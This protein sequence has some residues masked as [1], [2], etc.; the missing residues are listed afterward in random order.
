MTVRDLLTKA[1]RT[2]HV[3]GVGESMTADDATDAFDM[4]NGLIEQTNIDKL[5]GNYQTD[6]IIPL[7]GGQLSYTIGPSSA[8]PN[9]IATRP[10]EILSGFSRRGNIDL[11]IF[12]GTKL[13]YNKIPQ[14]NVGISG[15]EMLA[16]YEAAYPVA[17]LYLYP[18]PLDTLTSVYL[19][20]MNALA[21]FST[22]D[23]VVS[24]PPGYRMWLQYKTA[25]RLAPEYGMPFTTDMMS[26]FLD[27]ESAL[28]RN[29]IKP[30]PVAGTGL[31]SLAKPLSGQYNIYSDTSK[32]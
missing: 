5:M 10:V 28:K 2:I 23:D 27:A 25:M 7:V 18:A 29:N 1:F 24:F 8:S 22:L 30:M 9:V 26:N 16:Y 19:T 11:P 17:T 3:L 15:W 12:M 13:D 14:K 6:L 32:N 21:P 20:V 31:T 4:L